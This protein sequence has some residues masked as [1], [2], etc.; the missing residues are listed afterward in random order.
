MTDDPFDLDPGPAAAAVAQGEPPYLQGLNA[1][2]R[3]AVLQTE[4]PVLVLAGAGTGK[5]TISA[6]TAPIA[7]R[8]IEEA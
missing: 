8:F 1:E 6:V 7:L 3:A 4:G 2:Q 5:A